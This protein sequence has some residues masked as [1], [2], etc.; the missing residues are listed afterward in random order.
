MHETLLDTDMLSEILKGRNTQVVATGDQYLA[1][2]GRLAFSAITFY[3]IYRGLRAT[4][5]VRSLNKFLGPRN[6]IPLDFRG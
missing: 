2:H 6:K 5:A 4:R 3:E 1:E